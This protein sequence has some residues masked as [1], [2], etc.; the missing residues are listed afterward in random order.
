MFILR[1]KKSVMHKYS[2]PGTFVV[3]V[4]CTSN[5]VYITARKVIA[6]QE[7]IRVFGVVTCFAGEL[8]FGAADCKALYGETFQI[9]ME[10]NAGR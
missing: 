2:H 1:L 6:V 3:A 5:T 8:S 4:G 7:P 9:Q 10:V